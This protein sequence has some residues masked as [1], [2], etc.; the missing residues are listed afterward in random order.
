MKNRS[1]LTTAL[2]GLVT[3]L[4]L[5]LT[6]GPI[7][8]AKT[9]S[10]VAVSTVVGWWKFDDPAG[11]LAT[12]A[13]GYGNTGQLYGFAYMTSDA[14]MGTKLTI[15]DGEGKMLVPYNTMLEP[16]K[17][18][19]ALWFNTPEIRDMDLLHHTSDLL[20]RTNVPGSWLV[21][22]VR[23]EADGAI[24]GIIL[25][26]VDEYRRWVFVRTLPG[27]ATVNEWHNVAFRWD[28]TSAALYVNG[29]LHAA[30]PYTPVPGTGL[31][32]SGAFPVAVGLGSF[33]EGLPGSEHEFIGSLADIRIYNGALT[34]SDIQ[35]LYLAHGTMALKT[36]PS[37]GP[38][39]LNKATPTTQPTTPI[40]LGGK[41]KR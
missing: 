5:G 35:S 30:K 8:E 24:C 40:R 14:T 4:A 12:D 16:E 38:V 22:G 23:I 15:A 41:S 7:V 13:S 26:D 34:E 6:L 36:N 21:Y 2:T 39:L 20:T 3:L 18:T 31:S 27:V 19:I 32:Y 10:A 11:V 1:K 9:V 17:G 37:S 33:W 25:E 29:K 28:G